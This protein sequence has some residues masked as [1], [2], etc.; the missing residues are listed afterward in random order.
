M[1]KQNTVAD[2]ISKTKVIYLTKMITIKDSFIECHI[3]KANFKHC[4]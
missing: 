2:D 4:I 1:T 3:E